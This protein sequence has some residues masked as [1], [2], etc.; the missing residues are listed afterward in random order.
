MREYVSLTHCRG[1][2][3]W[4]FDRDFIRAVTNLRVRDRWWS[5]ARFVSR[6]VAFNSARSLT[7][8]LRGFF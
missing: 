1:E 7:E 3:V 8:L 6:S 4:L 2:Q 5:S